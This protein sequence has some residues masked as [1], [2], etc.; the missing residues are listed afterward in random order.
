MPTKTARWSAYITLPSQDGKPGK[1]H[2][3]GAFDTAEEAARAWDEEAKKMYAQPVLNYMADGVTVNSGR[4]TG[5]SRC[6][7]W[8]GGREG[9]GRGGGEGRKR[10][11]TTGHFI[12]IL[13]SCTH[14]HVSN[15][16]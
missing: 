13:F 3:L 7:V 4:F 14:P 15:I 12:F 2:T 1:Q 5:H 10:E 9:G 8:E 16:F 6:V 11:S